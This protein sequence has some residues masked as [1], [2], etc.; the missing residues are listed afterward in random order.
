M[1]PEIH[2]IISWLEDSGHMPEE[3]VYDLSCVKDDFEGTIHDFIEGANSLAPLDHR[4][5]IEFDSRLSMIQAKTGSL[6]SEIQNLE[7][8]LVKTLTRGDQNKLISDKE[9]EAEGGVR[10]TTEMFV[11]QARRALTC[12]LPFASAQIDH[13][14]PTEC[15]HENA[16]EDSRCITKDLEEALV[17]LE[18]DGRFYPFV[19]IAVR[20]IHEGKT[21]VSWL[22]SGCHSA[23]S[24]KQTLNEGFGPFRPIGFIFPR[25]TSTLS[26]VDLRR[27]GAEAVQPW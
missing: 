18:Q 17:A 22:P 12:L 21:V 3:A 2:K 23:V 10:L 6:L 7:D 14:L 15:L 8:A 25:E 9:Y 20:G 13:Q 24:L 11:A 26:I 5:P 1:I 4:D 16:L 27:L 19:D